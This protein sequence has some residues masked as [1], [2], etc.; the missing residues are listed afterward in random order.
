MLSPATPA[1]APPFD[2]AVALYDEGFYVRA[3]MLFRTLAMNGRPR[4]QARLAALH[5][6]GTGVRQSDVQAYAWATIAAWQGGE[7]AVEIRNTAAARLTKE[8]LARGER[9]AAEY[10]ELYVVPYL[11]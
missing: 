5:L 11:E 1:W 3:A 6:D 7:A 9:V 2:N 4:A 10:W 8:L